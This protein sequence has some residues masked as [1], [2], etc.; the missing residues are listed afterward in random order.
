MKTILYRCVAIPSAYLMSALNVEVPNQGMSEAEIKLAN[1]KA[2][3][4]AK[5]ALMNEFGPLAPGFKIFWNDDTRWNI[6]VL[7]MEFLSFSGN[8]GLIDLTG[9]FSGQVDV[10]RIDGSLNSELSRMGIVSDWTGY[11]WRAWIERGTEDA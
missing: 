4:Q 9:M 1:I 11:H 5:E 2:L 3:S 10:D 7:G 6:I 8:S